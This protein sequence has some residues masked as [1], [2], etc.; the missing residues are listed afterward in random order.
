MPGRLT[1]AQW[2]PNGVDRRVWPVVRATVDIQSGRTY[3]LKIGASGRVV[4]GRVVLPGTDVWMIRKA[5]IVARGPKTERQ[6]AAG[7]EILDEGRFRALDIAPGEYTL[8]IALH[9]PPPGDSCGWGRLVGEYMRDFSVPA[10][11][12]ASDAPFD[13]GTLQPV[14]FENRELQVGDRAPDFDVETLDGQ[15]LTLADFRGRYILLD[16]WASWCA[17]CLAEMP[18]LL[19]IHERFEQDDRFVLVGI[20]LDD[21]PGDASAVVK[22]RKL[23]WLHGFAGP[24]SPVVTTYGATAIPAT[25]LIGP[26][27]KIIARDL[28]GEKTKTAVAEALTPR[29]GRERR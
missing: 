16:F 26:D 1:L 29:E 13:L 8:R 6:A 12:T 10:G 28:R 20:S 14:A 15:K 24:D 9:E 3:D 25:F 18:G 22:A 11:S 5:E 21:K 7:V 19:A 23:S 17:P 4:S 27:G 2:V